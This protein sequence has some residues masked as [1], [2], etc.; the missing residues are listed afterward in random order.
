MTYEFIRG[1]LLTQDGISGFIS[2]I[3]TDQSWTFRH[4]SVVCKVVESLNGTWGDITVAVD[5]QFHGS[6][7]QWRESRENGFPHWHEAEINSVEMFLFSLRAVEMNIGLWVFLIHADVHLDFS[8]DVIS[9]NSEIS[10]SSVSINRLGRYPIWH[11]QSS[12]NH[13]RVTPSLTSFWVHLN[14]AKIT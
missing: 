1:D 7:H 12:G 14:S 10:M 5:S 6:V 11:Q 9:V 3:S 8:L 4:I 2:T 13:S